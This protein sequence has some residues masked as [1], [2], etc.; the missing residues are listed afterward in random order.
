MN[1]KILYQA[2][3]QVGKPPHRAGELLNLRSIGASMGVNGGQ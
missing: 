2:Y 3:G 1:D